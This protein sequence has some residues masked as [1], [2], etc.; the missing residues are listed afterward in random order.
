MS[1]SL[2]SYSICIFCGR[3]AGWTMWGILWYL[4]V[5]AAAVPAQSGFDAARM[6]QIAAWLPATPQGV[7]STIDDRAAWNKLAD[8]PA[9][10]QVVPRAERLLLRP[11]P[12][13]T[14]DL[15]LDYSRTGNRTRCQQVLSQRHRRLK[16][17]VLAECLENRGRFLPAIKE[18]IRSLAAE[19]TWVMPAHDRSLKNFRGEVHEIDLAVAGI[20]WNLAT[21][22]YWLGDRLRPEL[23][24][25]VRDQLERR[26]FVPL[27]SFVKTGQPALWWATGTNNWNAVCLAGVTG[28]ALATIESPQRRAWFVAAAEKYIENFLSGFTDHGYCWEGVGYWNYGFG[29]YVLLAETLRQA[30][31][32]KIDLFHRPKVRQIALYG[33]RMEIAGGVYP[34]FADCR[35]A[36]A[37]DPR[38]VGLLSRKLALGLKKAE[39]QGR[40]AAR[41]PEQRLFELGIYG[42]A[43]PT[44]EAAAR[45]EPTGLSPLRSWF[46]AAGVLV[47][48]M[49]DGPSGGFGAAIKGGHNGQHHNHNDVGSFVVAVRGKAPLLDP[50]SEIYTARTFSD[51]RYQ[52]NV[53]NSFGHAV[54]RVAGRLQRTGREAAARV[55]QVAFTALADTLVL[56]LRAAYDVAELKVLRRRFFFSRAAGGRLTVADEVQF[57]SPQ[58]FGTALITFSDWNQPAGDRLV[59][60]SGKGAVEVTIATGGLAFR[61]EPQR[62]D[63]NLPGGHIPTRLGIELAEPVQKATITLSIRPVAV[64]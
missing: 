18:A 27:E 38:I 58:A 42:F 60:G 22:D 64:E 40:L 33:P 56:D 29:H 12:A 52:S 44:V 1:A 34:A 20:S 30:T 54:P 7:G 37:P 46:P 41:D 61:V 48:R 57:T 3:R 32:G 5:F 53:L 13:L 19:K 4:A 24:R 59:V 11:M 51:Q 31:G 2:R 15:Y 9:F 50:G 23:R 47:C 14:D 36:D 10:A 16:T 25:L 28:A 62:L 55:E 17:L 39:R 45:R 6:E 35:P 43:N 49:S 8:W 63:E 26:T 21:A